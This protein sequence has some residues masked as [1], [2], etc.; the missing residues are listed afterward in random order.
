MN[1]VAVMQGRLLPPVGGRL[2]A[3]PAERWRDEFP[4]AAQAGA[5]A[6]E[7]IYELP[8]RD[9]NPLCT[10]DG[11]AEMRRLASRHSVDVASVCA[12]YFMEQP[13]I[14]C[15]RREQSARVQHLSWLIGRCSSAGIR[16]IVLPF[17]DQSAIENE[18][19]EAAI[20]EALSAVADAA[21]GLGIELHLETA[22][23]P[24][25]FRSLLDRLP[26]AVIKANYDSGNSAAL[27]YLPLEEFE[28]Y[29]DRIGSVHVKDRVRGGG[30]VP[31]G[32]GD[33]DLETV[34]RCLRTWN[35]AGDVVLQ[36]ARG[37]AGREVDWIHHIREGIVEVLLRG[38]RPTA[39]GRC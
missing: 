5:T 15:T 33:A 11:V 39:L 2:Q 7:W 19:D 10:D 31:L 9:R 24:E 18:A 34:F 1:R 20:V 30:T 29:G 28:A 38:A 22:L 25:R 3:F 23:N 27:G 26:Q 14:R 12:D 35:Y 21:A 13:L 8:N 4:L 32:D 36:V 6:I 16:R 37:A 17:V